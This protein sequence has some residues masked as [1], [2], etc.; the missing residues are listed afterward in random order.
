MIAFFIG[1]ILGSLYFGGLYLTVQ[2]I[3]KSKHPSLLMS[4]S[5]FLRLGG[6]VV[7]FF[8]ISKSG[9]VDILIALVGIILARFIMIYIIKGKKIKFNEE[10]RTGDN[11]SE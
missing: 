4:L 10:G 1:I 6:L 5:L 3:Y 9:Y 2:R 7:A 8:Y 11:R